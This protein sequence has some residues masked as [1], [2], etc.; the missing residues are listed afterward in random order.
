MGEVYLAEDKRLH[1]KVAL[2]LLPAQ[3]THDAE[4]ARRFEREARAASATNHPNILTIYEIGHA[5]GLQFIVTEFVDGVTLRQSMADPSSTDLLIKLL[6][7]ASESTILFC[8]VTRPEYGAAGWKLV[9]TA[10]AAMGGRLTEMTIKELSETDSQQLVFNLLD[11]QTLPGQMRSLILKKADGNPFFVEEV[12]R[13]LIDRGALVKSG[14]QWSVSGEVADID[15]P[16]NLQGL[17]M[18][19]IDRLPDEEKHILRVAS[20][21]GRQF[22]VK[23]LEQVV[24]KTSMKLIRQLNTLESFGLIRLLRA[25]PELEYLFRHALAQEAAYNSL[26]KQERKRLHLSVGKALEPSLS[27]PE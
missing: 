5:E 21:I 8:F 2:K 20:V 24:E 6:P 25:E 12:I 1:R 9:T 13:M 19:R 16:D 23:A 3:F 10:R 17:L 15:I 4:R 26:L 7:L 27:E 14:G 11:T 22:S 18:A